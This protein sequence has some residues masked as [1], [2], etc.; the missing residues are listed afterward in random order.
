MNRTTIY[1]IMAFLAAG[2]IFSSCEEEPEVGSTLYPVEEENFDPRIFIN[3]PDLI[4]N[5]VNLSIVQT[6]QDIMIP[7]AVSFYLK[8][9]ARVPE[10]VSVTVALDEGAISGYSE[11]YIKL[12]AGTVKLSNATVTIPAGEVIS[13]EPVTLELVETDELKGDWS[14]AVAG[15]KIGEVSSPLVTIGSDHNTLTACIEKAVTNIK[16]QSS[17]DITALEQ[18]SYD[19]YTVDAWSYDDYYTYGSWEGTSNISDGNARTYVGYSYGVLD[20]VISFDEPT[21]VSALTFCFGGSSGYCPRDIEF[22]TSND[23]ENWTSQ[24]QLANSIQPS[25]N[26]QAVP[27][28]FYSPAECNYFEILVTSCF[29]SVNYGNDYLFPCISEL[30]LYK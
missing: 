6:P 7:D 27:V 21:S 26:T 28:V 5:T 25:K 8:S 16:G 4:G 9:T 24:G 1:S 14:K 10:D 17:D 23:Y 29:Y 19:S 12:S 13:S 2:A 11:E 3:E 18:I 30:K 20:I 15:L 22:F